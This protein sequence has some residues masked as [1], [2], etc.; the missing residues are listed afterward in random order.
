M[1]SSLDHCAASLAESAAFASA[2]RRGKRCIRVMAMC[3]GASTLATIAR[4]GTRQPNIAMNGISSMAMRSVLAAL[5]KRYEA[6]SGRAV[7]VVSVGG[8]DAAKRV[9]ERESFDFVVLAADAIDRLADGRWRSQS[10]QAPRAP[11][12]RANA[13]CAMRCFVQRTSVTRRGRA[14]PS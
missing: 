14:A 9:R 11:T 10:R 12:S 3:A 6:R 5:C 2:Y 7:S 8:V 4:P 1:A 13:G